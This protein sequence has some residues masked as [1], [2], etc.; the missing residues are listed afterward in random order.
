MKRASLFLIT[1]LLLLVPACERGANPTSI[2]GDFVPGDH[3]A[4]Y[5]DVAEE[6]GVWLAPGSLAALGIDV[7]VATAPK[8]RLSWN[9]QP[10]PMRMI[11]D[12]GR[13]GLFFF[14]PALHTRTARETSFL[15]EMDEMGT[16]ISKAEAPSTTTTP[17]LPGLVQVT[18]EEDLRYLPQ[19]TATTPWFWQPIYAPGKISHT[20]ALTDAVSGPLTV[21]VRLWSH[22]R[23][24]PTPDHRLQLHWDDT[25]QGQW[26]WGGQGMQ[27]LTASWN[28]TAPQGSHILTLETPAISDAGIAIV[29]IDGWT[30]TYPRASVPPDGLLRAQGQ[31]LTVGEAGLAVL[32]VT[33]ALAPIELGQTSTEGTIATETGHRY[34]VGSFTAAAAPIRLRPALTVDVASLTN[35]TYLVVAPNVVHKTLEPLLAHRQAEGLVTAIITPQAIYDAFGA[36]QPTPEAISALVHQLPALRYLLLAGDAMARPAGYSTEDTLRVVAP[37]T[38]TAVLGETPADGIYSVNASGYPNVAVG[39]FPAETVAGIKAM[40]EKTLRWET[41]QTPPTTIFVTDNE[42]RFSDLLDAIIPLIPGAEDAERIDSGEENSRD[43]LLAAL[44]RGPTW[45][46]Y[47]GHG[48]L[49]RLCDEEILTIND[50]PNWNQPS[51][52]VAWTCLAGHFAHPTQASIAEAWLQT[53]NGGAVAFL[54]PVGETTTFEQRPMALVFY[55]SLPEQR[56]LG[57]AWLKAIQTET[58]VPDVRWGFMVLG[59]PAL[60]ITPAP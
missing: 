50:G 40:V 36:G 54:G 18:W 14:A 45:F 25:L 41:S 52:V 29:W 6:G 2:T 5:V 4:F 55:Q 31:A 48:S 16:S 15:L 33:E 12:N 60:N 22:T 39:R 8:L 59:D 38:R 27:A 43:Q 10:V 37:F 20:I 34:W 56:R 13:W 17:G 42:P 24:T 28:E 44:N 21:T 9:G 23:F 35:T 32:D 49:T 58:S 57:D 19:A 46:N 30:I 1:L 47:A 11:D 51:V 7:E 53:P 3:K 26:D